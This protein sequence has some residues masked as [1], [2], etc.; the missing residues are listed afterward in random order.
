MDR[1]NEMA[2]RAEEERTA[3]EGNDDWGQFFCD[4]CWSC[5]RREVCFD[6]QQ[7]GRAAV[8]EQGEQR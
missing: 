8:H 4:E 5:A 3:G 7:P 2:E 6:R 1:M